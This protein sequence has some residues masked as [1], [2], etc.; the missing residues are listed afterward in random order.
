MASGMTC[1]ICGW[2][3]DAFLIVGRGVEE[4]EEMNLCER[5]AAIVFP[6]LTEMMGD[7]CPVCVAASA[8]FN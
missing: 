6:G 4:E 2:G 5:C 8:A 7:H 3:S 1:D